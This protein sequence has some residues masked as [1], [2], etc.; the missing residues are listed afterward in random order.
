M[1]CTLSPVHPFD[2]QKDKWNLYL[3]LDFPVDCDGSIF[4]FFLRKNANVALVA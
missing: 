1:T 3:F 2:G 4:F